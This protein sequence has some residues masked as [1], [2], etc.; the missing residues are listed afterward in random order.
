MTTAK[1]EVNVLDD[2]E[3]DG[4][5]PTAA[6][7]EQWE[8]ES[9]FA[10]GDKLEPEMFPRMF[11][12]SAG[13]MYRAI[14]RPEVPQ[15]PEYL[16]LPLQP[17]ATLIETQ[18]AVGRWNMLWEAHQFRRR[19]FDEH[20]LPAPLAAIADTGDVNLTV[21]PRTTSRYF[22]YAPLYHLLPRATLER[23]GLPLLH[24]GQ[25]PYL[26]AHADH[27]RW[28]PPQFHDRLSQAWAYAVWPHLMPGSPP[29]AFSAHDPIRLLA[30]NL[31]FW[32][33]PVTEVIQAT[34]GRVPHRQQ[35]RRCGPRPTAERF[36]AR[37]RAAWRSTQGRG[38]LVRGGRGRRGARLD[39]RGSRRDRPAARHPGGSSLAPG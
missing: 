26:A 22:E 4:P 20:E 13:H 30:H 8:R 25:W 35:R 18:L 19:F 38:C 32:I 28:L 2:G 37:G 31:D 27:D 39:G 3:W 6:Q 10:S 9:R 33:P 5:P 11:N 24:A 34:L 29:S 16:T 7:I 17:G 1:N 15:R 23:F 14:I 12:L 21:V 36:T